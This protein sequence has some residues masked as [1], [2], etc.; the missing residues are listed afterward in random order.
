MSESRD[1]RLLDFMQVLYMCAYVHSAARLALPEALLYMENLPGTVSPKPRTARLPE[2]CAGSG[3]SWKMTYTSRKKMTQCAQYETC[4]I[5]KKTFE[6]FLEPWE[7]GELELFKTK[8]CPTKNAGTTY[9]FF[10]FS[11]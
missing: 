7:G 11:P 10:V 9:N 5:D 6:F 2:S 3:Y 4:K 8:H 1:A